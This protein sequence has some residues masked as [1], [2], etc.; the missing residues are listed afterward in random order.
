MALAQATLNEST[1]C[2]MGMAAADVHAATTLGETPF[3]S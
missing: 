1:P 3:S 2:A